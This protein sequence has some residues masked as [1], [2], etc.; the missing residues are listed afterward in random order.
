MTDLAPLLA[1]LD[2]APRHEPAPGDRAAAVLALV[3]LTPAPALVLT[4][5]DASLSRHPG[6]VSLPGG[7]RDRE[8]PSLAATALRETAEEL[9]ID[10]TLPRILGALP[11]VHTFVSGILVTPFVA[12]LDVLPTLRVH[13]AEI[14]RVF[15]VPLADLAAAEE[16]RMLHRDDRGTVDGWWYEVDGATVWGAT[17]HMVHELL[18]RVRQEVPPWLTS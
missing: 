6:E 11:P 18:T 14:A 3:V 8:D 16:R 12:T 5:R 7:L 9:G 13:R 17:G 1:A 15:T 4:E 2:P 10:P